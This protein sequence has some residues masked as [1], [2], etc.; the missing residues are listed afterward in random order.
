VIRTLIVDDS[1]TAQDFLLK[2]LAGQDDIEV[3]GVAANGLQAVEMAKRLRPTLITMDLWM[4]EMDGLMATE[5]I[6]EDCPT[7]IVII[8]S[9]VGSEP[10][11]PGHALAPMPSDQKITFEALAAGALEVFPKAHPGDGAGDGNG[12]QRYRTKLLSTLRAMAS[13][14]VLRRRR[15]AAGVY[16]RPTTA[17]HAPALASTSGASNGPP[18]S[19]GS[20]PQP[21]RSSLPPLGL[22]PGVS[23]GQP[24]RALAR[25]PAKRRFLAIGASTGGPQVLAQLLA[26]LP[27]DA[28]F[29]IAVV[30]HMAPGFMSGFV[31][32]LQDQTPLRVK[33]AEDGER[34]LPATVYL[35]PEGSHLRLAPGGT[36][37]VS[38][39]A[40]ESPFCP[41]VDVL[42]QSVAA[43]ARSGGIGL[44]LTGMGDDGARGM[45]ELRRVGGLA[46]AQ[47]GESCV[48]NGMPAAAA[49]LGAVDRF[50]RPSLMPDLLTG[51]L[52]LS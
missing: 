46:L 35:A 40:H 26:A 20:G 43:I 39:S 18:P 3:V 36:F 34:A 29:P 13:V 50:V 2:A 37:Q 41:S 7:R 51:A 9:G 42:F 14:S 10:A 22:L 15:G 30:Q 45:L 19:E 44:L 11:A 24:P 6:M 38:A 33:L 21:S 32:W 16:L 12:M 8:S 49:Q 27:A 47:E 25:E 5:Q 17:P 48:V 31:R 23:P 1:P 52:A 28:P 4:P